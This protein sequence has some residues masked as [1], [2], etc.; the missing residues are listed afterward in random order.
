[1]NSQTDLYDTIILEPRKREIRVIHIGSG[2][3]NDP[4]KLS[5]SRVSLDD[6]PDYTALSYCWGPQVNLEQV[7][8]SNRP[9]PISRHLHK[10]L[11]SLRRED[12]PLTLWI[13]AICIN[14]SSNQE[15]NTQVPLMRDIYKGATEVLIWLGESTAGLDRVFN[16]IQRVIEHNIEIEP[17]GISQVAEEL[18]KA[19]PDETEQAFTEFVN[20]PW[21]RRTWIIQELALP[22]QDPIFLCGKHRAPWTHVKRWWDIAKS[23]NQAVIQHST[24]TLPAWRNLHHLLNFRVLDKLALLRQLFGNPNVFKNGLRL[25][26]LIFMSEESLAT[27]PRDKI[28]GVMGLANASANEKIV[29]DYD[30]SVEDLYEE[31]SRYLIFEERTLSILSNQSVDITRNSTDEEAE[32]YHEFTLTWGPNVKSSWIRDFGYIRG[33]T[34][35]PDP[36]V[37]DLDSRCLRYNAS[38]NT[39]PTACPDQKKNVLSIAGTKVGVVKDHVRAWYEYRG[40]IQWF[41]N[42]N[43]AFNVFLRAGRPTLEVEKDFS[44]EPFRNTEM[45]ADSEVK[46]VHLVYSPEGGPTKPIREAI[47]RTFVGDKSL[48]TLD[49]APGYFEVFFEGLLDA[50]RGNP[51]PKISVSDDALPPGSDVIEHWQS[52]LHRVHMMIYRRAAFSTENGWIGLGPD[53]MRNG[54]VVVLLSGGDVPFVLRPTQDGHTLI[55][56]CYVEGM[57]YGEMLKAQLETRAASEPNSIRGEMFH[58]R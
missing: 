2:T 55:G 57:M 47:W 35:R 30:K 4:L 18:L 6:N 50:E 46:E 44:S 28:Y 19:S 39:I 9:I 31:T 52:F 21:F 10:C 51:S 24:L 26:A 12:S 53:M 23:L 34:H 54:D 20:I 7:E 13:D 27:N 17:K 41:R 32:A 33:A 45:T 58:I 43:E 38:L 16:S 5:L 40:K 11:V 22:R 37:R 25:S 3:N 36:L 29:V 8:I 14:Q 49:H 15:K 42:T 48:D 1:M 56:E